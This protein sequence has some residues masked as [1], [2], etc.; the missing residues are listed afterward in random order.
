MK[1][2]AYGKHIK[3][4]H[5]T[6]GAFRCA[7][8]PEAFFRLENR[9]QHMSSVHRGMFF[10]NCCNIQF[11]QNSRYAKHMKDMHEIDVDSS[12]SYEVDLKLSDLKF[13]PHVKSGY[14]E[15][16]QSVASSVNQD[17]EVDEEQEETNTGAFSRD[18][19]MSRFVRN[20]NKENRKCD[21]C[22]KTISKNSLYNHLMRYHAMTLPFKCPF[23][24]L[25]LE[26]AQYRIRHIQMF[27]PDDYKCY[28]CGLQF[29]THAK[30]AEHMLVEHNSTEIPEKSDGEERDL[31]SNDIKYVMHRTSE[32][33]WPEDEQ[34]E[35]KPEVKVSH[36]FLKPWVKEEP[37]G[38]SVVHDSL[39]EER[40][41]YGQELNY[42]DFKNK[43]VVDE[44]QSSLRCIPCD[45]VILR[46]SACAHLRLWHAITMCYNCEICPEGFQR[47]DYRQRHMKF[48]HPD[49]FKCEDCQLQFHRST[50]YRQHMLENHLT[51]VD[52]KELKTKDEIDVPLE[53]M[54][55]IEH[56]PDSVRVSLVTLN[57]LFDLQYLLKYKST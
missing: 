56:V 53:N 55:F 45:R 38:S 17:M 26:R 35:Q 42:T 5:A 24:D 13:L 10:C 36:E 4:R 6:A 46:T 11:Y 8:C 27:H 37:K 15:D 30:F 14:E 33:D 44:D 47:V 41:N 57:F 54:K 12:D 3:S 32:E 28:E 48:S 2:G 29:Q 39:I 16:Q 21:A 40:P 19:F 7:I 50:L 25:R 18:E 20:L 52:V 1:K 51:K 9:I 34:V 43:Y 23:C 31:S 22:D 49:D